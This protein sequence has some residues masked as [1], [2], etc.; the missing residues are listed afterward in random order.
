MCCSANVLVTRRL[1]RGPGNP[2]TPNM[3]L[4]QAHGGL[5]KMCIKTYSVK[6]TLDIQ[7]QILDYLYI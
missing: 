5:V 1:L 7:K 3:C 2:V 6:E 4:Y